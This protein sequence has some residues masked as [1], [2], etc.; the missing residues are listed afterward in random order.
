M[1]SQEL[2][3]KLRKETGM[4]QRA[5]AEYF[6]IPLRTYEQWERGKRKIP[7]YLLRLMVYKLK[8]EQLVTE[9]TEEMAD[10]AAERTAERTAEKITEGW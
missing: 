8:T 10:K 5:F 6:K 9:V 3:A 4:T 1:G 2:I 7:G